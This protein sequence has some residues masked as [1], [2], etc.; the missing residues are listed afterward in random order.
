MP[1]IEV[2][3]MRRVAHILK[4]LKLQSNLQNA[5]VKLRSDSLIRA[6]RFESALNMENLCLK[7]VNSLDDKIYVYVGYSDFL[8][9][10]TF[11]QNKSL[12]IVP[13]SMQDFIMP[14][15]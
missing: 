1:S 13:L 14:S 6:N 15:G 12:I 2:I 10:A 11:E 7:N 8:N 4:E 5:T 9:A 3:K